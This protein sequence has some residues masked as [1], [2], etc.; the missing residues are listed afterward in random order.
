MAEDMDLTWTLYE[1]GWRVR[2]VPEAISYPI[3]PA[4]WYF[5]GKQLR[6]WSHGFVQNVR[7]HWRG[8][9][10]QRYLRSVVAIA[11]FDAIVAPIVTLFAFPLLAVLVAPW[12]LLGYVI[13]SPVVAIPVL[14]GARKRGEIRRAIASLP[15]YFALRLAN[16]WFMLR[17][18]VAELV[19]GRRL[20]AYE[21]G[22]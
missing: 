19:V 16:C 11:F 21:K 7:L 5:L 17:A 14:T 20:T 3:E 2:F 18:V 12:F 10:S 1:R 22:H 4:N 6:R 9:L 8:L 15:A 13:D